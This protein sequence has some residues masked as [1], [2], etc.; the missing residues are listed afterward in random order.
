MAKAKAA[1]RK[2]PK[3]KKAAAR[4]AAPKK[5]APAKKK[6]AAGKPTRYCLGRCATCGSPCCYNASHGGSHYCID[7]APNA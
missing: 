6:A 4:K 3:G 2:A 5:R 7:H 1:K